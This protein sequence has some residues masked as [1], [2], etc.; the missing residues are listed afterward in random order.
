MLMRPSYSVVICLVCAPRHQMIFRCIF[1]VLLSLTVGYTWKVFCLKSFAA[2]SIDSVIFRPHARSTR[3]FSTKK[4]RFSQLSSRFFSAFDAIFVEFFC[5]FFRCLFIRHVLNSLSFS[6]CR[7]Q[8]AGREKCRKS[9][10]FMNEWELYE[11][12][13]RRKLD[14]ET[15]RNSEKRFAVADI[16]TS[17]NIK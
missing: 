7:R 10:F 15:A 4:N 6:T 1:T 3:R 9:G 13:E 14:S 12:D 16:E 17:T 11:D 2:F 5:E 8:L